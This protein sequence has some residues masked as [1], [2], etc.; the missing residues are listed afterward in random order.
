MAEKERRDFST[1]VWKQRHDDIY[2]AVSEHIE[3]FFKQL[4]L[5][6]SWVQNPDEA[7]LHQIYF[8]RLLPYDA[9]DDTVR[10]DVVVSAEI[11]IYEHSHSQAKDGEVTKWFRVSC[12]AELNRGLHNFRIKA[13]DEYNH[14]E[15]D[16][17][18]I[19]TDSLV[20]YIRDDQLERIAEDILKQY[21]PEALQTPAP[22]DVWRLA[23]NIG[24][25][26]IQ[27]RLSKSETI[28]GAMIFNDCKVDFYDADMRRFDTM[29]VN[30]KTILVDPDVYF[31]RTLGSWNNT[32]AHECVHWVKHRKVFEL[33]YL[34]NESV[35][36]IRCQVAEKETD[37]KSRSATEWMEWHA[38]ALAPRILMPYKSFKQKAAALITQYKREF[39]TSDTADIISMVIE[40]LH[41]FFGVSIQA[42]KIRMIDIGYTEA[43]GIFEYVDDR[44]IPAHSF[45]SGAIGKGQTYTVPSIDSL[46]Q[47]AFNIDLRRI[48]DTGNFVFV[49]S[50][51]CINDPRY[52][53]QNEFGILRMTEYAVRH[54]D[55][56]CLV[57]DRTTRPNK[58]YGAGRY[59]ECVLFQKAVTKTVNDYQYNH[60]DHNKEVEVR[61]S[62]YR[63][64]QD[65]V[66]EAAKIAK[67][68]PALFSES[69]VMLMK[70]KRMTV[71]QLAEKALT[72][73]K[74]IQR[75]RTVHE[76]K[77]PVDLVMS[78]CVG[79]N[80]IP[81]LNDILMEKA[82][83]RLTSG[84][85]DITYKH[86]LATHYQDTIFEVNEYL[87][88]A[89]YSRLSG[90]E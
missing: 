25:T 38:N 29:E 22:V 54:M 47:Y 24:L 84:E 44:Y 77:W 59:T 21:Y 45:E 7:Y 90:K 17:R 6:T 43:I 48:L 50:H 78:V 85:K 60:N 27:A 82:G 32:V 64:E 67:Q 68:L 34:Y 39:G 26:I 16:P 66:K 2:K 10:F 75:M 35:R 61:A 41:D 42:A 40:D 70:W 49:D 73:S 55:E 83:Y 9:P 52:I 89:G 76:R 74:T 31:L 14:H 80:L 71:E 62:T 72:S 57:F 11:E 23:E 86:L 58:E 30:R 69:L 33:E 12:E 20:P 4:D 28:F 19:L 8:Q 79:L 53:T 1:V 3:L 13:V 87:E 51:F 46:V 18:G 81:P 63:A 36:M 65:E 15:N 88:T 5:H 37:D 56:C